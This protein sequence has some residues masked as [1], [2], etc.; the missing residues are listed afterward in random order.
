M[1]APTLATMTALEQIFGRQD[2]PAKFVVI[3]VFFW[4]KIHKVTIPRSLETEKPSI[5]RAFALINLG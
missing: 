4:D 2:H 5:L 3:V 1:L